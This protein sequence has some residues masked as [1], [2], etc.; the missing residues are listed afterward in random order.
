MG[1]MTRA[2]RALP[3]VAA[4]LAVPAA[5]GA[6]TPDYPLPAAPQAE[7]EPTPA[8]APVAKRRALITRVSGRVLYKPLGTKR[9]RRLTRPRDLAFGA[10]VDARKGRVR[11][12]V[13][14]SA[15]GPR[16]SAVF[17]SGK[18]SLEEQTGSPLITTLRLIGGSFEDTCPPRAGA[19]RVPAK[20]PQT[21]VRRLWGDGKGRFRTRGRYS[22]ATVRGTKWLVEDR[23]AGTVTK[24]AR[25]EV[26]VEDFTLPEPKPPKRGEP[27]TVTVDEGGGPK[28]GAAP[29][30][31]AG[32]DTS[33]RRRVR[34]R[35][36]GS[37]TAGPR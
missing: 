13:E 17:F 24:V 27:E 4:A 5:V 23:C 1:R 25:G 7:A 16:S 19:S 6:Q 34:V 35:S 28:P 14:R 31:A 20:D 37:Y 12:T 11:V 2:R 18:F 33:G 36:G 32:E 26:E 21:R 15:D 8:P 3:L 22:A 10:F 29:A 9:Y 30:P